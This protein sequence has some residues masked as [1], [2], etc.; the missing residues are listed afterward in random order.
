MNKEVPGTQGYDSAIQRFVDA[1]LSIDFFEL[2]KD[3][4]PFIPE[5]KS[6]ILDVGAGIG[7][8]AHT[9]AGMGHSVIA[10]EPT[11]GL[12]MAGRKLF[13]AADV[14]SIDDSLPALDS[15]NNYCNLF[16]LILAS[17][18]WHH[19]DPGEQKQSLQ[20]VAA[21]LKPGG[22]LLLT[23]RNGP[24]GIGVHLFP[25]DARQT[26]ADAGSFGLAT[27]LLLENVPSMMKG[28]DGVRWSK[29]ALVR[30]AD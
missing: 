24:A 28:K 7:R 18:I 22:I 20:R 8:D 29:L 10:V 2:H 11:K 23:L 30:R 15:L 4:L 17:G 21:L 5:K 16:D 6:L 19:L 13:D 26:I 14:Q 12:R 25:T 27:L 3:F 1:T 9:L